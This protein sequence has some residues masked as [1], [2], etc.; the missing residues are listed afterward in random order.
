[1]GSGSYWYCARVGTGL[2]LLT[3]ARSMGVPRRSDTEVIVEVQK[4]YD[5]Y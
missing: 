1:M 3:Y 5:E 4:A 2:E